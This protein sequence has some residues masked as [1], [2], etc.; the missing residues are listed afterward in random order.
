MIR[1]RT[2]GQLGVEG[3]DAPL[4]SR[5]VRKPKHLALLTYLACARGRPPPLSSRDTLVAM[6]WPEADDRSARNCLR[7]SL[8]VLRLMLGKAVI[9]TEGRHLVGT[10]CSRL[11]SDLHAFHRALAAKDHKAVV[12][13]HRGDFLDGFFLSDLPEFER[14]VE[15]QRRWCR[16]R[17][18]RAAWTLAKEAE[19]RGEHYEAYRWW[20]RIEELAPFDQAVL[21]RVIQ[22][23]VRTGAFASAE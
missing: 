11:T 22:G 16:D 5:L 19:G 1:L 9:V 2:F 15:E 20:A 8:H 10:D 4:A 14:W 21:R 13:L 7:Q 3:I 18:I 12:D 23:L 6:F 17:A